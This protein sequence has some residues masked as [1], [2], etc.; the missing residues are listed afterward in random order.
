MTDIAVSFVFSLAIALVYG[1]I[2]KEAY[3]LVSIDAGLALGFALAGILTN[4]FFSGIVTSCEGWHRQQNKGQVIFSLRSSIGVNRRWRVLPWVFIPKRVVARLRE[5]DLAGLGALRFT[6]CIAVLKKTPLWGPGL[7][8]VCPS[9]FARLYTA[10]S[11]F[12][13]TKTAP[14]PMMRSAFCARRSTR[15]ARPTPARSATRSCPPRA[16]MARRA[17]TTSTSSATGCTDTTS[18]ATR[19]GPS[20]STS[21]SNSRTDRRTYP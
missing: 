21:T 7:S 9:E 6:P 17:N 19:R 8:M 18:C 1:V 14:G 10:V 15:R 3:P 12:S 20:F 5:R 13:Q 16:T 2:F 11:K 4:A